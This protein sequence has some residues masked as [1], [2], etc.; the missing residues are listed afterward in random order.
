VTVSAAAWCKDLWVNSSCE[1][2]QHGQWP[3]SVASQCMQQDVLGRIVACDVSCGSSHF[4]ASV[5]A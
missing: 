4:T 3:M 1:H 5:M 2:Q